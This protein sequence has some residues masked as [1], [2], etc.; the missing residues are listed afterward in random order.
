MTTEARTALRKK[1][2]T[3]IIDTYPYLATEAKRQQGDLSDK[4]FEVVKHG[5]T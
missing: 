3:Q 1:I 2:F 4:L 5:T